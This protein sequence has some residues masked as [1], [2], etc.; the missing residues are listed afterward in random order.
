MVYTNDFGG[1]LARNL[2]KIAECLANIALVLFLVRPV[3]FLQNL[4]DTK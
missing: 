2:R 3:C 1:T 4:A